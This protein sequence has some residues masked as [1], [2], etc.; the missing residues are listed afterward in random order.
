[1]TGTPGRQMTLMTGNTKM[2]ISHY[3]TR[4]RDYSVVDHNLFLSVPPA[5]NDD[6]RLV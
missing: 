1:M 2:L 3:C 4:A 6:G 5:A